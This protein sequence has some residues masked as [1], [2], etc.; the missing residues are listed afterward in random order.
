MNPKNQ[1]HD[2]H[3]YLIPSPLGE[4]FQRKIFCE[5]KLSLK[6]HH[7]IVENEKGT[8]I[9]QKDCPEKL[10]SDLKLFHSI[11]IHPN[12]I[13]NYLNLKF[14]GNNIGLISDAGCPGI[15]DPRQ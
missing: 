10:H 3:S 15:A 14:Y 13:E 9:H 8:R 5:I 7:F 11:N 2:P 6:I 12:R 4:T 1:S